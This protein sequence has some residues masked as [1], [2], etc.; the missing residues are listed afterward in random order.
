MELTKEEQANYVDQLNLLNGGNVELVH[1]I[2]DDLLCDILSKLG[3][4]EI[5]AAYARVEKWYA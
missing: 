4:D 5:V 2:A 1:G 3:Y